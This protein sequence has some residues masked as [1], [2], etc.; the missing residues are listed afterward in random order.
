MSLAVVI[1]FLSVQELQELLFQ[2]KVVP[3]EL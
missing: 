2:L 3:V 1:L